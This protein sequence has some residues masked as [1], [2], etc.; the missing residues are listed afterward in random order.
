M[1]GQPCA[2][3]LEHQ[4]IVHERLESS[5]E[6]AQ[7]TQNTQVREG[8][9]GSADGT[10][11]WLHQWQPDLPQGP[12]HWIVICTQEWEERARATVQRLA[13]R[14]QATWEKRLWHLGNQT[15][16]CQPDAEAALAKTCQRLP[17]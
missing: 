8:W 1:V 7:D 13:E 17:P 3:D 9:Q 2:R 6:T 5:I 4:A 15:F 11:H 12:E 14:D 10:G 16:A